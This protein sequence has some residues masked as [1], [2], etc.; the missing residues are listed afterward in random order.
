MT[1]TNEMVPCGRCGG[2]GKMKF[3]FL[4]NKTKKVLLFFAQDYVEWETKDTECHICFGS[5]VLPVWFKLAPP[6]PENPY[7]YFRRIT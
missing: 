6:L 5:G 4:V 1:D 7:A 2:S 3:T